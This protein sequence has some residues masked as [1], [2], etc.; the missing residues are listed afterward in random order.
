MADWGWTGAVRHLAAA[1]D[2]MPAFCIRIR[3]RKAYAAGY[4]AGKITVDAMSDRLLDAFC[5][6]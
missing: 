5:L 6:I 2:V 3:I 1:P 4:A